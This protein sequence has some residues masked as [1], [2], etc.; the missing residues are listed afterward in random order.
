MFGKPA[1][2]VTRLIVLPETVPP[3]DAIRRTPSERFTIRY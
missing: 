2:R 3:N 1:G